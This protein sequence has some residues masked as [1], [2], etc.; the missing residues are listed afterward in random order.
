[1]H[2]AHGSRYD[3]YLRKSSIRALKQKRG[4]QQEARVAAAKARLADS[5]AA[6]QAYYDDLPDS[7]EIP[8]SDEE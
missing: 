8:T 3:D 6:C 1:M 5:E 7:S 2:E 4:A